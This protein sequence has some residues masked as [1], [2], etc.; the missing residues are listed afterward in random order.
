[1][2][3]AGSILNGPDGMGYTITRDTQSGDPMVFA[4]SEPFGGAPKPVPGDIMPGWVID[5]LN[6]VNK[7]SGNGNR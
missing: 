6:R 3:K 7:E 4:V 2:I 5:E 1:M